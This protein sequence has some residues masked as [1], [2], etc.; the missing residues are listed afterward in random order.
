MPLR[1]VYPF[2]ALTFVLVYAGAVLFL[3]EKLTVRAA[4]GVSCVL[5]GLFLLTSETAT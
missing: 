5:A 4:L 1:V 3:G 2:T